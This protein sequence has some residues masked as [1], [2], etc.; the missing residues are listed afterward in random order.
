MKLKITLAFLLFCFV[1]RSQSVTFKCGQQEIIR[2]EADKESTEKG[3]GTV[4]ASF[5]SNDTL[6]LFL[7]DFGNQTDTLKWELLII[8]KKRANALFKSYKGKSPW[9]ITGLY[10]YIPKKQ[11]SKLILTITYGKTR[12]VPVILDINNN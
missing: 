7:N 2:K 8:P 5:F 4:A 12:M 9:V 6:S 3:A 11:I 1:G 10:Q